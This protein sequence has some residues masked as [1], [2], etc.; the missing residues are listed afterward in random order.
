[1]SVSINKYAF[2]ITFLLKYVQNYLKKKMPSRKALKK[3]QT[4][5]EFV[6]LMASI[7]ILSLIFLR[8]STRGL[9][10]LWQATIN[11]VI[12]PY[13]PTRMRF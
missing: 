1:M 8:V 9:A 3:G 12:G 4:L 5:V 6:L 7:S 10:D 2:S 11:V 13:S